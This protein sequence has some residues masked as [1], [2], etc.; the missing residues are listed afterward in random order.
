MV[1]GRRGREEEGE[2]K[3]RDKAS[4]VLRWE[5]AP[6]RCTGTLFLP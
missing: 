4:G 3:G 5:T 6:A 2:A 1:G